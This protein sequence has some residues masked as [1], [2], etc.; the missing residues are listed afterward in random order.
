MRHGTKGTHVHSLL[1]FS[2]LCQIHGQ[3]PCGLPVSAAHPIFM[4]MSPCMGPAAQ[5]LLCIQFNHQNLYSHAMGFE[6]F[7]A[8]QAKNDE[9]QLKA[10]GQHLAC[11]FMKS[12]L[13]IALAWSSST[14]SG[15]F[16]I[17]ISHGTFIVPKMSPTLWKFLFVCFLCFA[18]QA[19]VICAFC[20]K[21][22]S[23]LHFWSQTN[24]QLLVF[25]PSLSHRIMPHGFIH[26]SVHASFFQSSDQ[27]SN[28]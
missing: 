8:G 15:L 20:D 10:K 3:T 21:F 25:L 23:L 28:W 13:S 22:Q 18:E 27:L 26:M 6:W 2:S 12:V 24:A 19:S 11:V 9:G 7:S 5:S 4:S 14:L 1:E 16:D 17:F